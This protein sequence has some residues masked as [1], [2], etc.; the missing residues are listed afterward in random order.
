MKRLLTWCL[1]FCLMLNN[2]IAYAAPIAEQ[3]YHL[4]SKCEEISETQ[5]RLDLNLS[6]QD[7]LEDQTNVNFGDIVHREWRTLKLNS[8][9]DSEI[10]SA[11]LMVN[12]NAGLMNRFQSSWIPSKAEELANEVTEIAFNAPLLKEKLNQLSRNV[13]ETLSVS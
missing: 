9:I 7:F 2:T 11:V 6:I 5:L 4:P 3:V 1:V 13:S 12:D 10:D 8:V